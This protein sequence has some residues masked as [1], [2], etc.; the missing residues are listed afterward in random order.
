MAERLSEEMCQLEI[1]TTF[2]R[3]ALHKKCYMV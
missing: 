1:K 2:Y 3:P